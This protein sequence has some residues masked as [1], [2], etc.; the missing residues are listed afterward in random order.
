MDVF[1]EIFIKLLDKHEVAS[2]HNLDHNLRL[3]LCDFVIMTE[4]AT[5]VFNDML[6]QFLDNLVVAFPHNRNI[7]LAREAL[8]ILIKSDE[9]AKR[10]LP[11]QKFMD[12]VK[13]HSEAIKRK[14]NAY[15]SMHMD[16]I[17]LIKD[18]GLKVYWD[19]PQ[20]P[21][22][23]RDAIWYYLNQLLMMGTM[24]S[25]VPAEMMPLVD[26]FTS[27]PEFAK[28]LKTAEGG[29]PP[30]FSGMMSA[31]QSFAQASGLGGAGA[32]A[33]AGATVTQLNPQQI[34]QQI[35]MLQQSSDPRHQQI[36][37]QLQ[38]HSALPQPHKP[39]KKSK[40]KKSKKGRRHNG[41]DEA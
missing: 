6:N 25:T 38:A 16:T 17:D 7:P 34:Q 5:N 8:M 19:S 20:L 32:G 30:D 23:T 24:V 11:M 10:Q 28:V 18:L 31:V 9:P 1:F 37:A 29:G 41:K 2:P 36:I 27:S 21:Q 22:Q 39:S 15:M 26:Q 12:S 13:P 33:G 14:D 35:S 4:L 40:K 3:Q